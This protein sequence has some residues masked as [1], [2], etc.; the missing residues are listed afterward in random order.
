MF[1]FK[2]ENERSNTVDINDG[3]NYVVLEASG[4]SPSSASLFHSKSPN[5]K[6][7]KYNGSTVN[8]RN[9]ILTI[10]ILG[11]IE[12]NRN[13]LYD[14]IDTEQYVKVYYRNGTKNVYCEGH[15]EDCE[16]GLF[17]NNEIINLAIIC[18]DPYW[19]DLNSISIDISNLLKQFTF[20]FSI[21]NPQPFSSL[22]ENNTTNIF[23]YGTET[24]VKIIIKCNKDIN[25]LVVYNPTDTTKRFEINTSLLANWVIEIDT[26]SSPKTVRAYK[27]DG[28]ME[29][30]L[31]YIGKNPTWF[32][33]KRG[34]NI[35]GFEVGEGS[36]VSDIEMS[37][38][39][40]NKYSGV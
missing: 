15:V 14:W 26:D 31:K 35:L 38:N 18:E 27:P 1:S 13:Y 5:R 28:T 40:T 10:K 23:N 22:K 37:V 11:D 32:T 36:D 7:V 9:I 39:F 8:E 19:K 3:I 24:G 21:T 20:P 33:L 25:G 29:N 17:T 6:G 4:L 30:F 12:K 16:I 34:N 2:L